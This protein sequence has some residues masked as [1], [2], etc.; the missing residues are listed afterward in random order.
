MKRKRFTE[1]Q[2]IRILK[3]SE[4]RA[5]VA[6]E[7]PAPAGPWKTLRVS[8]F[9]TASTAAIIYPIPHS[10]GGPNLGGRSVEL[11]TVETLAQ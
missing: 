7:K 9:P 8:H 1:E 2:I 4:P 5:A 10:G 11:K 6:V 3:E